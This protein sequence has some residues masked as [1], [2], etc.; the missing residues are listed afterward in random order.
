L[1]PDANRKTFDADV[2]LAAKI[3]ANQVRTENTNT[4]NVAEANAKATAESNKVFTDVT[5]ARVQ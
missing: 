1:N 3:V 5:K 2:K 4:T